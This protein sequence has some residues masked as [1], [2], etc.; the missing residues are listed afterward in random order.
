M[1][2]SELKKIQ[3]IKEYPSVSILMP[4]HRSFPENQQDPI[5]LKN[6]AKRAETRLLAEFSRQ[7]SG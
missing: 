1:K 2:R 4:T 3:S 6:L 5:R 7:D